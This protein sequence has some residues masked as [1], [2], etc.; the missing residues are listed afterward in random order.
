MHAIELY[1]K[2]NF[3]IVQNEI[4][5]SEGQ[6][7]MKLKSELDEDDIVNSQPCS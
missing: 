4:S 1:L 6:Y 2:N 3:V 7:Y 5:D